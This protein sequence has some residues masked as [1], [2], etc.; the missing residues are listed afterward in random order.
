M[1][2]TRVSGGAAHGNASCRLDLQALKTEALAM[3]PV[4]FAPLADRLLP[5]S[6][7][8]AFLPD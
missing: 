6:G 4:K 2:G 3:S 7:F 8:M 1:G 5:P